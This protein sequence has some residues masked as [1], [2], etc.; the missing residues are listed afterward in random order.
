[1]AF[2]GGLRWSWRRG[3]WKCSRR[4]P[5]RKRRVVARLSSWLY[6]FLSIQNANEVR[7]SSEGPDRNGSLHRVTGVRA[8]P[9]VYGKRYFTSSSQ[10]RES[11]LAL[12]SSRALV[13]RIVPTKSKIFWKEVRGKQIAAPSWHLRTRPFLTRTSFPSLLKLTLRRWNPPPS[14]PLANS[15]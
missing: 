1:M 6:T 14:E 13:S 5:C 2:P 11:F 10:T 3:S 9:D 7:A 12:H 15:L 4:H 8:P